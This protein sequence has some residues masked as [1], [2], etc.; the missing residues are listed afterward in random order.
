MSSHIDDLK[1]EASPGTPHSLLGANNGA[2]IDQHRSYLISATVRRLRSLQHAK[3]GL[4]PAEAVE[5][6]LCDPIRVFVKNEPHKLAK[7]KTT[8]L[9]LIWLL[10]VIDQLVE[11]VLYANQTKLEI[12]NWETI[13]TKPGMGA[14][15][16]ATAALFRAMQKVAK[17]ARAEPGVSNTDVSG[18]DLS[19]KDW[20]QVADFATRV[21]HW[22]VQLD[23]DLA[24]M[25]FVVMTLRCD[26]II[27]LSD[28]RLYRKLHP[29]MQISG[30]LITSN[31]NSRMR[32]I[33]AALRGAP[34]IAMGDDC[35][36]SSLG[37]AAAEFYTSLGF[38]VDESLHPTPVGVTFCSRHY[39][40]DG[41]AHLLTAGRMIYRF[42]SRQSTMTDFVQ[43]EE[44][45]RNYPEPARSAALKACRDAALAAELRLQMA[46]EG[47]HVVAR[48]EG[49][50]ESQ[51][52]VQT[53]AEASA[54]S[55][56]GDAYA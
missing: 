8:R 9:R 42:F 36:E 55:Q 3:P 20:M 25:A 21:D 6:D 44:E 35:V 32:V 23:S 34:C 17:P 49:Q 48:E 41:R 39:H 40:A 52:H 28:G 45:L 31:G 53:F 27:S 56:G 33:I 46:E 7:I 22:G 13:P 11:R 2:L 54:A 12:L 50:G 10:S 37:E 18:W 24:R 14:D 30:R 5:A 38:T 4:K 15:N 26:P 29:G 16:T 47:R 1:R 51:G 19:V 43:L